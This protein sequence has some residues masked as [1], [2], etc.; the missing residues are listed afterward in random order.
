M[1]Y[2]IVS[3]MKILEKFFQYLK[4]LSDSVKKK[5]THRHNYNTKQQVAKKSRK[6]SNEAMMFQCTFIRN[7]KPK[8]R[9]DVDTCSQKL[10]KCYYNI[11]RISAY[12]SVL[13]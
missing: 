10:E 7:Y 4:I 9:N 11:I 2:Y 8:N 5:V 1:S 6:V 13:S 12:Q 3:S